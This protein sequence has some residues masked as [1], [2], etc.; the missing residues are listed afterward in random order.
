VAAVGELAA[1]AGPLN[2][3]EPD[4]R[5]RLRALGI[6]L[7]LAIDE[8]ASIWRDP[9]AP[10][11][12]GFW[13]MMAAARSW[14]HA[15]LVAGLDP[16]V[17]PLAAALLLGRREGIDPDVN[18]AFARTGTVHLLAISG[19]HLQVL[20]AAI[21][22]GCRALGAGWKVSLG[23]VILA[24]A[25]YALLV[26]LTP[27]VFRSA[28]MTVIVCLAG[29]RDRNARPA[30]CLAVAALATL[31]LNPAHLFDVGCQLSFLGV[32]ALVWGT[33]PALRLVRRPADPLDE[34]ERRLEP[35]WRTAV[36][37]VGGVLVRGLVGSTVVGIVTLPLVALRFHLVSPIGIV[38]NV[39]LIPLTSAALLASGLTLGLSAVRGTLGGRRPGPA[40]S[41]WGGPR[42]SCAGG[43]RSPGGMSTWPGPPT[44]WVLIFYGLLGLAAWAARGRGPHR[45]RLAAALGAWT[46]LGPVLA[47]GPARPGALEADV[48]AVGHGLAVVIQ[49]DD[50][51]ALLYDCG[52]MGDP[53]VGRRVIAPALWARRVHRLDAVVLSHADADH[54]NGLPELLE[55]FSIGEVRVPPGFG[56]GA[57]PGASRL[58]EAVRAR[59][60]PVRPIAAGDRL[61][62]GAAAALE[63][64]HPP[65]GWRPEAPDNARSVVLDLAAGGRHLLLTGDL[66]GA[67][68]RRCG[69][70]RR[71]GSPRSWRRTTAAGRPTRRRCTS[72]P[73]RA[74]SSPASAGPSRGPG[75]RWAPGR[76]GHRGPADLAT[77]GDPPALGRS[78]LVARGFLDEVPPAAPSP[79]PAWASTGCGRRPSRSGPLPLG[80]GAGGGGGG[81]VRAGAGPVPGPGGDRVGGLDAG[82]APPPADGDRA[83]RSPLGADRGDGRRRGAPRGLWRPAAEARGARR[84]CITA[85]A[86]PGPRCGAGP[87]PCPGSAGASPCR[88]ARVRP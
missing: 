63:V 78:G 65:E 59:G 57:N 30:D 33:E 70:C 39:P 12:T 71:G 74:W 22:L 32:A 43:R 38:L 35:G 14:S 60:V 17:A 45:R 10:A 2:P 82:H 27:S 47:L 41:C 13:A 36:R 44:G 19:L 46:V 18:D 61:D 24:T 40:R 1:V 67:A 11:W 31:V 54:Y 85:S 79:G 7:R 52:R 15:R 21:F 50:G 77:R 88:R 25:G 87:G 53:G 6:R 80:L 73:T 5:D 29:L 49:A 76:S 4:P 86:R 16:R 62:L 48:L 58:L 55:R 68:W 23:V 66:E 20:A 8:P 9:D 3:G 84:C 56:G 72:G 64:L 75:T 83:G 26:G 28:T 34:L 37:R 69:R 42:G 51:R 81:G